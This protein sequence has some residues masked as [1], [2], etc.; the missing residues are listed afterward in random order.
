MCGFFVFGFFFFPGEGNNKKLTLAV[1]STG[2]RIIKNKNN[3]FILIKDVTGTTPLIF[4][5]GKQL[6][7]FSPQLW[8]TG[9]TRFFI[10]LNL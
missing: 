7:V 5:P 9:N 8:S 3:N 6:L 2:Q 1:Q 10:N 4:L